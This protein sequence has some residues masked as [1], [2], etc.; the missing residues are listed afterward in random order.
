[1]RDLIKKMLNAIK[2]LNHEL[3]GHRESE[4]TCIGC[5]GN[6]SYEAGLDVNDLCIG[7]HSEYWT[8][9]TL[10]GD[11]ESKEI[12]AALKEKIG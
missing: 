1:M 5:N 10:E 3:G 11:P 4:T 12:F 6:M 2:T 8:Y 7:H 9:R